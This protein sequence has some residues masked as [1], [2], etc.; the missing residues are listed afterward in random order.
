MGHSVLRSLN[1]LGAVCNIH[2]FVDKSIFCQD[3]SPLST[4]VTFVG[5]K[6]LLLTK[7]R[8]NYFLS[9]KFTFVDKINFCLNKSN[10]YQLLSYIFG[11][12]YGSKFVYFYLSI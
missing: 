3:R 2:T 8:Q 6:K 10:F 9:T 12:A 7:A 4:E 11:I 1:V 5:Q